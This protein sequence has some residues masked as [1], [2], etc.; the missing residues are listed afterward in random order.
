MSKKSNKNE[1][2]VILL[3]ESGTGKTSLINVSVGIKFI[4]GIPS[5]LASSYVTKKFTKNNV[6]Y[7]L[8]I[9]DTN[10]QEKYRAMT[11]LFIKKSKIVVYVYAT[12]TMKSFQELDYW[13]KAVKDTLG[14]NVILGVAGNKTDLYLREEVPEK[15]GQDFANRIGAKFKLVSA[16]VDPNG[17]IAFLEELL[18]EYLRQNGIIVIN[19]KNNFKIK[20]EKNN[21]KNK[22]KSCC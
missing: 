22:K 8:D 10:G 9:W 19:E 13:V 1:L 14:D 2:K 6:D 7:S 15:D 11:K 16:K 20:E 5:T 17:F 21:T 3:G 12:D 18:E 4:D